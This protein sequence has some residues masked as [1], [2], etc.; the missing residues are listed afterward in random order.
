MLSA[1][2]N[3][4]R[5]RLQ[6]EA[7]SLS[8]VASREEEVP[9]PPPYDEEAFAR[10]HVGPYRFPNDMRREI[11][12]SHNLTEADLQQVDDVMRH[13]LV[14]A[15]MPSVEYLVVFF[16]HCRI[17]A[18]EVDRYMNLLFPNAL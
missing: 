6:Q 4:S 17:P 2:D 14:G 11:R 1:F 10:E 18:T 12:D 8:T 7:S 16:Q 15:E 3:F 5:L 9:P 13:T